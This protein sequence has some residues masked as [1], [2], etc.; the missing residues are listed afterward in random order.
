MFVAP[1]YRALHHVYPDSYMSSYTTLF[2]RLMGT[3]CQI[4]GRHVAMTGA[5]GAFGSAMKDLLERA[6]ATVVPLK[7]GVD[8]TYEDYSGADAVLQTADILVL[9]HG[10]KGEQAMRANCESFLAL[11]ERFKTLTQHRLVPVEVWAVGSEIECHPAFGIPQLQ[12]YARSKRAF[13]R[14]AARLAPPGSPSGS[15]GAGSATSRSPTPASPS[16]TSSHFSC[17]ASPRV[18]NP[19]VARVT[20]RQEAQREARFDTCR[21]GTAHHVFGESV[22][23]A[24]P[25]KIGKHSS[26]PSLSSSSVI[27]RNRDRNDPGK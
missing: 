12:S 1:S 7:F 19:R 2:D 23:G 25:T 16:S 14:A 27:R 8:F 22:G 3:A 9:A 5:S 15:S 10:A 4:R 6:G 26:D 18:P 21:V 24:H 20:R 13:A 17:G 11:I